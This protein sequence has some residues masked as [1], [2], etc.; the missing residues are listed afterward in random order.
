M[1]WYAPVQTTDGQPMNAVH[2]YVIRMTKD[3]LPPAKAFWSLTLYD[4][5]NGFFIPNN[6]KK[7]SV[8]HNAGME[9]ARD[10]GIV[11][12]IAAERPNG[13]AEENWLPINRGDVTLDLLLRLY[14]PDPGRVKRWVMP[15][16]CRYVGL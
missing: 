11:I 14:V 8:G 3:E 9:L 13:V 2:D 15:K 6:Q 1:A 5:Q 12:H 16:S 4:T 7:Y 10:G